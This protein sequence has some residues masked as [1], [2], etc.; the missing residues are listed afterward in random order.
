MSGSLKEQARSKMPIAIQ[1]LLYMAIGNFANSAYSPLSS[2]IKNA[3]LLT[4]EEVGLITSTIFIGSLAVSF[5][6]GY[7]VDRLGNRTALR[8]SFMFIASGSLVCAFSTTY[9]VLLS[10][11]FL[12]GFGYGNITPATNSLIM[13]EYYPYHIGRMGIKQTGVPIGSIASV[14]ILPLVAITFGIRWPFL[15]LFA[16]SVV[17][18]VAVRSRSK[19]LSEFSIRKYLSDLLSAAKDRRLLTYSAFST[20]LSWGQQTGLTFY[21]LYFEGKGFPLYYAEILLGSFLIGAIIGRIF[22]ARMGYRIH[23]GSR[24]HATSLIMFLSGFL[25]IILSQIPVQILFLLPYSVILGMNAAGWN[26]TFVTTVSEMAGKGRIGL[27]SGVALITLG[28]GTIIGAPV[29]GYIRDSTDS[30]Y[31]MW[32][33]LGSVQVITSVLMISSYA[34]NERRKTGLGEKEL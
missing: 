22:W 17:I 5:L 1:S 21:V 24:W 28:L 20:V 9:P 13:E 2:A 25:F 26:S 8:I 4:S 34:L 15:V 11:F 30:Y 3:Y 32:I 14:I 23:K 10:G 12:I 19:S 7:F 27:Y 18:A 16:T 31:L 33:V 29:S 6:S